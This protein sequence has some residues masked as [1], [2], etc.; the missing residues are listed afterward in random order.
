MMRWAVVAIA[1]AWGCKAPATG[2]AGKATDKT[3]SGTLTDT[4][5]V[6]TDTDTDTDSGPDTIGDIGNNH[7]CM[8]Q[9]YFPAGGLDNPTLRKQIP[10]T[11]EA[12]N[13]NLQLGAMTLSKGSQNSQ[14]VNTILPVTNVGNDIECLVQITDIAFSDG[15]AVLAVEELTYVVGSVGDMG[16]WYTETCVFPG[17]TA[18]FLDGV[19]ADFDAITEA[20]LIIEPTV[21]DGLAPAASVVPTSYSVF[22]DRATFYAEHT[23][24]DPM[25]ITTT[26]KFLLRDA[27]G[28][29]VHWGFA[30]VSDGSNVTLGDTVEFHIIALEL[31]EAGSELCL[32]M[33][34]EP[35]A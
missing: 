14:S 30:S 5:S 27:D 16:S 12:Q 21:T 32:W 31:E 6:D 15:E 8:R 4:D 28:N 24:G 29:P 11:V 3:D 1:V 34:F 26:G 33:H 25:S 10:Y 2:S 22:E 9:G 7:S 18:H 35:D 13:P 17:E 23:A 19:V 20:H